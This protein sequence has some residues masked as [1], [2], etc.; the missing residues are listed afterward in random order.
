M[1][2][3]VKTLKN[4]VSDEH[5]GDNESQSVATA[6]PKPVQA[7]L[8]KPEDV[9]ITDI[10]LV[11]YNE[12]AKT[13][14]IEA[15]LDL[16]RKNELFGVYFSCGLVLGLNATFNSDGSF[17]NAFK[18]A[19][20]LKCNGVSGRLLSKNEQVYLN[21]VAETEEYDRFVNTIKVLHSNGIKAVCWDGSFWCCEG[22]S[23]T[24]GF[25]LKLN[26]KNRDFKC[27]YADGATASRFA[28]FF[29]FDDEQKQKLADL[30]LDND[31]LVKTELA[32]VYLN[33]WTDKFGTT[34]YRLS[35]TKGLDLNR[36]DDVWGLQLKTGEVI[37]LRRKYR[38]YEKACWLIKD[39]AY[40]NYKGLNFVSENEINSVLTTDI[41][42]VESD[43]NKTVETLSQYG[44]NAD[45][46]GGRCWLRGAK[47]DD[48]C[49]KYAALSQLDFWL[50]QS[51]SIDVVSPK[52]DDFIDRMVVQ[53][54]S[55]A[56]K[57]PYPIVYK[58]GYELL[59][60]DYLRMEYLNN[61]YGA[62]IAPR[63]VV[64][65]TTASSYYDSSIRFYGKSC[66]KSETKLKEMDTDDFNTRVM[67][68]V[69]V[70]E[71]YGIKSVSVSPCNTFKKV[72]ADNVMF[73]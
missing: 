73:F 64:K 29:D 36:K 47:E 27:N 15:V 30:P 40:H 12:T 28:V 21:L 50:G 19:A 58:F 31:Y 37:E 6:E 54:V 66:F 72:E 53:N 9:I 23:R 8:K 67:Q 51:D 43:F 45:K 3:K 61:V 39:F 63:M 17:E 49:V 11:Y 42:A 65:L 14:S 70:L 7:T 22:G 25:C 56:V 20:E 4:V 62:M 38:S 57:T 71:S 1:D 13:L 10:P 35:I 18:Q 46:F 5:V 60:D 44:I 32:V 52:Q 26:Y 16:D 68:I 48:C 34:T 41:S 59:A 69:N 33:K 55:H 2:S 24:N